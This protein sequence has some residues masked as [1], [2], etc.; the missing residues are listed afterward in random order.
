MAPSLV[1][2]LFWHYDK[3]QM[4]LTFGG[5]VVWVEPQL[6]GLLNSFILERE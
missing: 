5:L 4:H 1:C 2:L 6:E 3:V